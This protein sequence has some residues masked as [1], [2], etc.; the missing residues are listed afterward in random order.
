MNL[1]PTTAMVFNCILLAIWAGGSTCCKR[2]RRNR[3]VRRVP[4]RF[5]LSYNLPYAACYG[6]WDGLPYTRLDWCWKRVY[7]YLSAEVPGQAVYGLADERRT[8]I[9][10]LRRIF[11]TTACMFGRALSVESCHEGIHLLA[12]SCIFQVLCSKSTYERLT[13]IAI[14]SPLSRRK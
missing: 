1:T 13:V 7:L 14:S 8:P 12:D 2:E 5:T 9:G 6:T 10:C 4:V 3:K 11:E